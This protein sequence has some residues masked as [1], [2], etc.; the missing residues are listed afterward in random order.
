MAHDEFIDTNEEQVGNPVE[1]DDNV[2]G[3]ADFD[4][5]DVNE[6]ENNEDL[7]SVSLT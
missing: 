1:N 4:N 6:D 5:G 2:G 7:E 3:D